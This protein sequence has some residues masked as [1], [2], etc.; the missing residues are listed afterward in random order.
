MSKLIQTHFFHF[1]TFPL[2]TKQKEEKI[3]YYLYSHIFIFSKFSII[4][5]F[6]PSNQTNPY[7]CGVTITTIMRGG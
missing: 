7:T 4:P 1:S 2:P 3:K 6:H 5:L